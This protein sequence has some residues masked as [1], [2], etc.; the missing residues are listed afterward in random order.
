[1][2][3][4]IHSKSHRV[5]NIEIQEVCR[6]IELDAGCSPRTVN[7]SNNGDSTPTHSATDGNV[8]F[9]AGSL[10]SIGEKLAI[11]VPCMDEDL[12]T[13]EGV[14][15]GIPH[16]CLVIMVSNS[17]PGVFQ[18]ENDLLRRFCRES[19]RQSIII[20]QKDPVLAFAFHA[21]GMPELVEKT[22][23][24]DTLSVLRIRSGKGEAMLIGTAI[25]KL[26]GKAFVGFI[27]AD[28][29]FS[30]AV[31]EYCKVYAAGLHHA[32]HSA[33]TP[34]P[35]SASRDDTYDA[36]PHAMVRIKWYSKPKIKDGGLVLEG[37][38]RSSRVVN[39]WMNRLFGE[40]VENSNIDDVIQT[41]NAGE[42]AMSIGLAMELQF[43]TGYAVEP[44]QLIDAWE[45]S[46]RATRTG[47]M[48]H[49]ASISAPL[50][51]GSS[52]PDV[53]NDKLTASPPGLLPQ[54]VRI[55][56]VQTR[57]HHIHSF[58]KGDQHI[59]NMQAQGLST[60]YHSSLASQELKSELLEFMRDNLGSALDAQSLPAK[61][62]K[63][64]ALITMS[65]AR[66]HKE[67]V[68]NAKSLKVI[69]HG[70]EKLRG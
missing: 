1:M 21:A 59:T 14:L 7:S 39:K 23:V 34:D 19:Y 6:V 53:V 33:A 55:L 50:S 46:T 58:N 52:Y 51:N 4:N 57:N 44:F 13:L 49:G 26:A 54:P 25:A 22:T 29:L 41:G 30:G 69:G 18:G 24:D 2:R 42:H 32:L 8:P 27:D 11:I 60:I 65:M 10:R 16:E 47:L 56:Q 36:S 61:M 38:G 17:S 35:E 40:L 31:H 62:P 15:Y 5:G 37:T 12:S 20:H 68:G 3:L 70:D 43:A 45:R 9:S 28:N 63:Y 66:F 64:P 67:L 48:R